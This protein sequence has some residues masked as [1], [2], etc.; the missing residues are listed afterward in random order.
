MKLS[1]VSYSAVWGAIIRPPREE[2]SIA[3]LGPDHFRIGNRA[4]LR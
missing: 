2:Y 3:D 1:E 4:Y